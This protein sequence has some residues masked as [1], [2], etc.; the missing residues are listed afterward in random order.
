MLELF[1]A[2][3]ACVVSPIEHIIYEGSKL[4]IPTMAGPAPLWQRFWNQLT[5]IQVT[6]KRQPLGFSPIFAAF[7]NVIKNIQKKKKAKQKTTT[8]NKQTK[9]THKHKKKEN[10]MA[11]SSSEGNRKPGSRFLE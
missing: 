3:T 1:G 9:K 4:Y 7:K 8:T 5:D 11:V 2:G 10:G 6:D